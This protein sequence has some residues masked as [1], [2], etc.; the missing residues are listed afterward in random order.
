[1]SKSKKCINCG[2]FLVCEFTNEEL[3]KDNYCERFIKADR[4]IRRIKDGVISFNEDNINNGINILDSKPNDD[5][6]NEEARG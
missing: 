5:T 4:E 3:T 1:M 2:R 6:S